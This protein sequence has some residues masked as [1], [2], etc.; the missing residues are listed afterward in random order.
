MSFNIAESIRR[1]LLA[2]AE[3]NALVAG[4]VT[5]T[6]APNAAKMPCWITMSQIY[7][8]E[9]GSH[10]GDNRLTHPTYQFT[11]GGTDKI[12]CDRVKTILSS[13]FNCVDFT[14]AEGFVL[15]FMFSDG[16]DGWDEATMTYMGSVD[17]TIWVE[18]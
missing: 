6:F 2:N 9:T 15:T 11:I 10:S 13:Q 7:G 16:R 8:G 3:L 17:L 1:A 12:K 4:N 14:D 18:T 5:A